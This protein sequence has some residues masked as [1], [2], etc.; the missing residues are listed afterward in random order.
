MDGSEF[1]QEPEKRESRLGRAKS[2]ELV[3][4]LRPGGCSF[5]DHEPSV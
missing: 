4:N 2:A 3:S 5:L 1:S